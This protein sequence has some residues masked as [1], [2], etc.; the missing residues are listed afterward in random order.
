M[1]EVKRPLAELAGADIGGI[2]AAAADGSQGIGPDPLTVRH[3]QTL[4]MGPM[5]PAPPDQ[6]ATPRSLPVRLST[7]F[8]SLRKARVKA[9]VVADRPGA[10]VSG[11]SRET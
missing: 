6:G 5:I 4:R 11:T 8:V 2:R 1:T 7:P 9:D 10:C 3:P